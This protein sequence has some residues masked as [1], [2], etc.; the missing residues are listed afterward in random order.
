MDLEGRLPVDA[1]GSERVM[2]DLY[3]D[4]AHDALSDAIGE[5]EASVVL[6]NVSIS[7]GDYRSDHDYVL[8][9]CIQAVKDLRD[10]YEK[11]R[12][13]ASQP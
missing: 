6:G 3:A 9:I 12:I 2:R 10:I 7:R 8:A 5:I 11:H 1:M 4:G 13:P